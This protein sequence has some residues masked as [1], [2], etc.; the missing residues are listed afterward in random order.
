MPYISNIVDW[1][2]VQ[3][4]ANALK[5]ARFQLGTLNGLAQ[6]IPYSEAGKDTIT[7][8]SPAIPGTKKLIVPEDKQSIIAYH[9]LI[10]NS[11]STAQ[12][13]AQFGNGNSLTACIS[14]MLMIVMADSERLKL[15]QPELEA[16][17]VQGLPQAMPKADKEPLQLINVLVSNYESNFETIQIYN[18]EYRGV[19]FNAVPS[20]FM[21]GIKYRIEATF[22]KGCFQI[23]DC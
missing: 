3:L 22:K 17:I 5:D 7:K 1:I 6:L 21:I 12:Q 10:R 2:N 16:L 18:Q 15:S 13:S 23:C 19:V 9:R 11:Y 20:F 4:K 14:D 8:F